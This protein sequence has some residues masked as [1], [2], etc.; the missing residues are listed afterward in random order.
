M[1][2]CSSI[3]LF[4]WMVHEDW[5]PGC[6]KILNVLLVTPDPFSSSELDVV[7][8]TPVPT[9]VHEIHCHLPEFVLAQ[10]VAV[11]I[12]ITREILGAF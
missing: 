7:S 5:R 4:F 10:P 1:R 12:F 11:Y 8:W 6:L 9:T 3:G 2:V